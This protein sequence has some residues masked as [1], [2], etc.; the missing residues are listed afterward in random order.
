MISIKKL[1]F[2]L[3]IFIPVCVNGFDIYWENP[4]IISKDDARFHKTASSGSTAAVVWHEFEKKDE[5]KGIVYLSLS[6][7]DDGDKWKTRKRFAGPFPYTG[8]E[9]PI[10][11]VAVDRSGTIYIAVS[12]AD[13]AVKIFISKDL[14]ETFTEINQTTSFN[15]TVGPRLFI[16]QDGLPILFVTRES[17]KNLSIFYSVSDSFNNWS[18]FSQLVTD[19]GFDLN[20]LPS[21]VSKDGVE[22][23]IY[24]SFIVKQRSTYQLYMKKSF[25][26]GY[27]WG[28]AVHLTGFSEE[29][30]GKNVNGDFFDNQ[31]PDFKIDS[32]GLSLVWERRYLNNQNPQI[33]LGRYSLEGELLEIPEK[34]SPGER[35]CNFPLIS[36]F[37]GK[38]L[39]TWFD[40]RMGDYR[41]VIA[42]HT[43]IFWQDSDLSPMRGNSVFGQPVNFLDRMF[44]FWENRISGKSKLFL[45]SPDT[46]VAKPEIRSVNFRKGKRTS[47][48][49][50]VFT[51]DLMD[52]ASGIAG[53]SYSYGSSETGSPPEKI[54]TVAAKRKAEIT[55]KEDGDWYFYL[56][57]SDYAG[58][59]SEPDVFKFTRDTVPPGKISFIEPDKDSRNFLSSNTFGFNWDPPEGEAVEGYSYRLDYVDSRFRYT[60]DKYTER[61]RVKKPADRINSLNESV[62]FSNIDNGVWALSVSAIDEA[63][64]RGEPE[65][66][67]FKTNKYVPVTYIT[68]IKPVIDALKRVNI[69]IEGR[70]FNVGGDVSSIILDRDGQEPWDN[71]YYLEN[72]EYRIKSDRIIEDFTVADVDEGMYRIGLVHPKR[73]LYFTKPIIRLEPG[74]TVKYGYFKTDGEIS[75]KPAAKQL[76]AFDGGKVLFWGV[77]A[78]FVIVLIFSI[79]RLK[80]IMEESRRFSKDI[81]AIMKGRDIS[82]ISR[83]ERIKKM[84]SKGMGLRI[85]FTLFVIMIVLAV[86]VMVAL[87]LG[88][89]MLDTQKRNLLTGLK[90]QASVLL[91]SLDSGARSFL[92]ASNTLELGLLPDQRTAMDDAV[93]VT[94]TGKSSRNEDG[95]D[96]LWASDDRN[97]YRKLESDQ[98]IPGVSPLKDSITPLL[99]EL[100]KEI[101]ARGESELKDLVEQVEKLGSEARRIV[102]RGGNEERLQ[103]LQKSIREIDTQIQRGMKDIGKTIRSY[104]NFD[105]ESKNIEDR[106]YLFY[107]PVIYRQT[108]D[109][110]Y[111]RGLVRLSVSTARIINEIDNSSRVLIHQTLIIAAFAILIGIIGSLIL[112]A[113]IISPIKKLMRGVEI[114]RDTEDK[115]ELKNVEINVN[116]RDEID[117]LAQTINQMKDGLVKAAGANKDLIG[118]KEIQK[119]FIPLDK[120]GDHK[121]STG[122]KSTKYIDLFGYYEGAKGVSGDYFDYMELDEENIAV[123]KCDVAGKGVA[124]S[125]IMVEVASFFRNYFQKWD[126]KVN[127][128]KL[129]IDI[130]DRIEERE[131]KGRFAALIL[132]QLN[133]KTGDCWMCHAG[134]NQVRIFDSEENKMKVLELEEA[135]AAG[136][137][138]SF[139]VGDSF[140]QVKYKLKRGDELFLFT[141]GIEE[142]QRHF[143]NEK[144][145]VVNCR[146]KECNEG[147]SHYYFT[148]GVWKISEKE[149]VLKKE[150]ELIKN[151]DTLVC[152]Y[153]IDNI[154]Q[155]DLKNNDNPNYQGAHLYLA[156]NEEFG[157]KRIDDI[158]NAVTGKSVYRLHKCHH[159]DTNDELTFDFTSCEGSLEEAVLALLSIERIF[160]I[161]RDPSATAEN[162]ITVDKKIDSFLNKTFD[163]YRKYFEHQLEVSKQSD[164]VSFS[165]MKQDDQYDDLTILAI[166][167]K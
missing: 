37:R 48:D 7:S 76:F 99:P 81:D 152:N 159:D 43:G 87:P 118:G 23:V 40:N 68:K 113:I 117:M 24:Q 66:Y 164:Y 122:S 30:N 142:S 51:W 155:P 100:E 154:L 136:V 120:V 88:R 72:N 5:E 157:L 61:W 126:G 55:V 31:R 25:D 71:I 114:I 22:Y 131:F 112:S 150:R 140:K 141:D 153:Y 80:V 45:L 103:E 121:K 148:D 74:G 82:S 69:R 146:A 161:Y 102:I 49:R 11:S 17:Q 20:F 44:I 92:P 14:G 21:F 116:T 94:I 97:I 124:G 36:D 105:T 137:F 89:F 67:L 34:V 133:V 29:L 129:I 144:F 19:P 111:Y 115:E 6:A 35:N 138:P 147:D 26:G 54:K 63:G 53:F 84:K 134:D 96:F 13:N 77:I 39:I 12:S 132:I 110:I 78:L 106:T 98:I 107:K 2:T 33:Y 128:K 95:Y 18:E 27:T 93:F 86:V 139:M 163:Q 109:D 32:K 8:N 85:K 151:K 42:E 50:F 65:T 9:V 83:K 16:K 160:R 101:N 64:N 60:M 79:A 38:E 62:S 15:M 145:K 70:G 149:V 130:N 75:W 91:E 58:N 59:W 4:E 135:P 90:Q 41:I 125:L 1:L 119:K 166:R 10:C 143:R 3:L 104:P 165:Y 56:S 127:L 162:I 123:I 158:L 52:D 156:E 57:A 73:G 46:S 167:R 108:G 28:E 47:Q